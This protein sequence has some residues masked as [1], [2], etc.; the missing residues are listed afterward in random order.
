MSKF[1]AIMTMSV[2]GFVADAD[3]ESRRCFSEVAS[4]H[5]GADKRDRI[6]PGY[7]EVRLRGRGPSSNI[8][9][10]HEVRKMS[11]VSYPGL[12]AAALSDPLLWRA[13]NAGAASVGS[14]PVIDDRHLPHP[15][16]HPRSRRARA[17]VY[18]MLAISSVAVGLG[19]LASS[20]AL[21]LESAA[22]GGPA[23]TWMVEVTTTTTSSG[24]AL[25]YGRE[26]GFH[27]VQVP[28]GKGVT[29]DARVVPA[30]LAK[31]ELHLVSLGFSSLRV[32]AAS[33]KGA[34]QMTFS[35]TS[36]IITAFQT[37]EATGVRTGW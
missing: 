36:P 19:L 20:I 29:S 30:R 15:H 2:D 12:R 32:N 6:F 16:P 25:I 34:Q 33:P 8:L 18:A 23:P 31:G 22:P 28:A 13:A 11:F 3:D 21:P 14:A 35:A 10:T 7:V 9:G 4:K 1:V 27:L 5:S 24:T 26:V 37:S 17:M